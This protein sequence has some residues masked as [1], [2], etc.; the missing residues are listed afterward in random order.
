MLIRMLVGLAGPAY[1]LS[2]GDERDFPQD[3][4]GRLI[5]AGFAAPVSGRRPER[6]VRKSAPEKR[7]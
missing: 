7:D 3:E 1:S 4:A 5:A 2:P 6:A